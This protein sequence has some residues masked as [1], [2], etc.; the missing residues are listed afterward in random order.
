MRK[1]MERWSARSDNQREEEAMMDD[2]AATTTWREDEDWR[3]RCRRR[4]YY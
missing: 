2:D 1:R 3:L 4:N